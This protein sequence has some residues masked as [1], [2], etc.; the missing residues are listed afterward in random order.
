MLGKRRPRGPISNQACPLPEAP[1]TL[2]R[3]SPL[4]T[5]KRAPETIAQPPAQELAGAGSEEA[6]SSE[7]AG[8]AL[9]DA[10]RIAQGP[11]LLPSMEVLGDGSESPAPGSRGRTLRAED[12]DPYGSEAAR[13]EEEQFRVHGRVDGW[14]R[15]SLAEARAQRGLPHPYVSGMGNALR[16]GLG[17]AEGGTPEA[18]GAPGAAGFMVRRYFD[19]AEAYAR[20]GNP[21]ISTPGLAERQSEKLKAHTKDGAGLVSLFTQAAETSLDLA[22]GKP[23]L[24]L[25]LELRLGRDGRPSSQPSLLERSGSEKF[26]SF[27]LRVVPGALA[28]LGPVPEEALRGREELRSVWLI[29]GWARIPPKLDKAMTMIGVPGVQ[30]ISGDVLMKQA[31]SKEQFDFRARLLRVY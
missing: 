15:D 7:P 2:P 3:P 8:E 17:R 29:E 23:L 21:G 4:L 12:G 26:D 28:E 13:R 27:V 9:E 14:A 10:P 19:S 25:T 5:K 30:G 18:L 6:E 22:Y 20:T 16:E 24:A 11:S 1:T 31:A